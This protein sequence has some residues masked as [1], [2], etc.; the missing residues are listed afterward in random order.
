MGTLEGHVLPGTMFLVIALSIFMKCPIGVKRNILEGSYLSFFILGATLLMA[1]IEIAGDGDPGHHLHHALMY[2]SYAVA[3]LLSILERLDLVFPGTSDASLGLSFQIEAMLFWGHPAQTRLEGRAHVFL[4]GTG[5]ACSC[6]V[7]RW[8]LD[9][10]APWARGLVLYAVAVH[11]LLF[12][13]VGCWLGTSFSYLVYRDLETNLL[14]NGPRTNTVPY[15]LTSFGPFW[16][17]T[18]MTTD[19]DIMKF[20]TY[21]SACFLT[22]GVLFAVRLGC[23]HR[24]HLVAQSSKERMEE[25]QPVLQSD[26]H[27]LVQCS[28]VSLPP[29]ILSGLRHEDAVQCGKSA[30]VQKVSNALKD[31]V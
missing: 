16:N 10:I 14:W 29:T 25:E 19:H 6:F 21:A 7:G 1:G 9:P 24:S 22:I 31:M 15:N 18:D 13:T 11:G 2:V 23:V 12:V 4:I 26:M 30:K 27:G 5:V 20:H 8:L 28:E 3:S 17:H